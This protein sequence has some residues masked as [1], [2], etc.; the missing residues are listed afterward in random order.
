M[1]FTNIKEALTL[2]ILK[3]G[4]GAEYEERRFTEVETEGGSRGI[5][6]MRQQCAKAKKDLFRKQRLVLHRYH[7]L[8]IDDR[9]SLCSINPQCFSA[10]SSF[11]HWDDLPFI[12]STQVMIQYMDLRLTKY[13]M[14][15]W[16]E[17]GK[18]ILSGAVV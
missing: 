11:F 4:T 12:L 10:A 3:E 8:D 7:S 14:N 18:F 1:P 15:M 17:K 13:L 5:K 6:R 2:E 16:K 9:M